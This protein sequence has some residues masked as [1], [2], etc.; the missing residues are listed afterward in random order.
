[1]WPGSNGISPGPISLGPIPTEAM[2]H[3]VAMLPESEHRLGQ[4][5]AALPL[6]LEG[7]S[8]LT[9][10][11]WT[12]LEQPRPCSWC[13]L[14]G[15][16]W[17]YR[18]LFDPQGVPPSVMPAVSAGQPSDEC[19]EA[20]DE[21]RA[22]CLIFLLKAPR[23]SKP[24]ERFQS[25]CRVAWAWVDA[26]ASLFSFPEA[27]THLPRRLLL[28]MEPE[29]LTADHSY[30]FLSNGLVNIEEKGGER[31]LWL[32]TWGMGQFGLPDL[33]ASLP[34]RVGEEDRLEKDLSS[35]RLLFETLPP[36]M[37]REQGIL[38]VG[39]TVELGDRTWT[40]VGEPGAVDY[41]F[42]RSRCGVQLFC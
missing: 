15:E 18:L 36:A 8:P 5:L 9:V 1:M 6:R 28:G 33:A 40:A 38:P 22:C 39:G 30:L 26:G 31:K 17:S 13:D 21:H 20:L 42:L 27:Q 10:G 12:A 32:R 7:S 11:P 34:S 29:N 25:L 41:P 14:E 2:L 4:F 16:G 23:E 3:V 24:F 35:L 19:Q 37:I